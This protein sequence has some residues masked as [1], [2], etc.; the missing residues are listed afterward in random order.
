MLHL[1]TELAVPDTFPVTETLNLMPKRRVSGQTRA[2]CRIADTANHLRVQS[3]IHH[4]LRHGAASRLP[5]R[6]ASFHPLHLMILLPSIPS[7]LPFTKALGSISE[8]ILSWKKAID[9]I[10]RECLSSGDMRLKA[11]YEAR[12]KNAQEERENRSERLIYIRGGVDE[13][14]MPWHNSQA[15]LPTLRAAGAGMLGS[16]AWVIGLAYE[17]RPPSVDLLWEGI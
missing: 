4:T 7:D 10:P 15:M 14:A 3:S 9:S 16:S 12:L 8:S 5:S 11:E 6:C 17:V 13:K 2:I 1:L